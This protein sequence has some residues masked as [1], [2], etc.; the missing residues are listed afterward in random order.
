MVEKVKLVY[1][2]L[3]SNID[4]PI[5]LLLLADPSVELIRSYIEKGTCYLVK[6]DSEIIGISVTVKTE[7]HKIEIMNIAIKE[8]FQ[9]RGI[10]KK[11]LSHTIEE[12]KRDGVE[13]I[14]I[15]TGNSSI[16]QLLFYQ[17]CGFRITSVDQDF[18]RRNYSEKIFENGI[19]CRDMIR[20]RID[21]VKG[22]S[23]E[24][25]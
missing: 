23:Y 3:E 2:K 10:G 13:S 8:E 15:G 4:A 14:E 11:L 5:E 19:E 21:L 7:A 6:L 18:F 9:N 16:Y 25:N 22:F 17:K 20:M 1:E 12:A 24:N